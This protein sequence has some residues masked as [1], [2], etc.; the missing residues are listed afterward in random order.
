MGG[1]CKGWWPER[2]YAGRGEGGAGR[3]CGDACR[4]WCWDVGGHL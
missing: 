2:E 3:E 1:I 4:G